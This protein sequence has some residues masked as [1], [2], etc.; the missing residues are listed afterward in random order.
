MSNAY[1]FHDEFM[2]LAHSSEFM[3]S[4]LMARL[5]ANSAED[6]AYRPT[7]FRLPQDG[8]ALAA[9]LQERPGTRISD[10]LP[11]QLREL[12]KTLHPGQRFTEED[13]QEAMARHLADRPMAQYGAWAYYPWSGHLVHLLDSEEFGLVRT[14]RNRNKITRAEQQQIGTLKVGVIGLSVGQSVSLT[15]ALER[16]FGEI[17]LADFDTLDLSNLNR[18]RTGVHHLGMNKAIITAREI[19]EID[20]YLNVCCFTD[21]LTKEN[22][23]AFFTLGGKLDIVVEECDSVEIKILARQK[24]KALGIPVVMDM[25]D[26]GC[27]DVERFDLEPDRPLLHGWIDHLDLDAAS[28]PMTAEEK[29]PYM[30]PITGVD[31]LSPRMKASVIELGQTISTWPQLAT[32]VVLGGALAGDAVRRIALGQ[33]R[34]SGR[35]Y[36]DLEELVADA[37]EEMPRSAPAIAASKAGQQEWTMASQALGPANGDDLDLGLAELEQLVKAGAAAPSVGNVQPWQFLWQHRRLLLFHD[38]LRS[39]SIWDPDH[40]QALIGLG[41]CLENIVLQ[42][43]AMGLEVAARPFPVPGKAHLIASISFRDTPFPGA[44]PHVMDHL[45]A[46]IAGRCTNRKLVARQPVAPEAASLLQAAAATGRGC[47]LHWA[48]HQEQLQAVAQLCGEAERLRTLD[49]H[50][51]REYFRDQLRWTPETA[52][53]TKDGVDLRTL[54]LPPAGIAALQV[55]SDRRAMDL[56]GQWG[57]GKSLGQL[58]ALPAMT[59]SALALLTCAEQTPAAFL[60]AGR[61]LERIWLAATAQGLSVHPISNILV[62]NGLP[63]AGNAMEEIRLRFRACWG[64]HQENPAVLLRLAHAGQPSTHS[65]RRSVKDLLMTP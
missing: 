60:E 54:E 62:A 7:L 53:G 22:L 34:T 31:T 58:A 16:C 11:Q 43:H 21:G 63:E 45:A 33:F 15:M 57:T 55:A 18:I 26:R 37:L 48:D 36:V 61:T 12:M 32:S 29:V 3:D 2:Q 10:R 17:R 51:H 23:D 64:L 13:L 9:L 27:L 46:Q 50:G 14:D 30:L 35:W 20:P 39:A 47:R 44:E 56:I 6:L 41:A 42:G 65:L 19:A 1:S 4:L 5:A 59:A 24:A 25:S 40:L 49:P 28:R 52:A 8:L 38:P